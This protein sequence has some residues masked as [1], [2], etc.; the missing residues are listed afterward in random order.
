MPMLIE[1][2]KNDNEED[3]NKI[4]IVIVLAIVDYYSTGQYKKILYKILS[5]NRNSYIT[6]LLL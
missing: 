2:K 3:E 1:D 6:E 4:L 5:L